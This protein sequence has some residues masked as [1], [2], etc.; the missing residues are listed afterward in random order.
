MQDGKENGLINVTV[1]D[2]PEF[3]TVNMVADYLNVCRAT[4]YNWCKSGDIPCLKIRNTLRIRKAYL[5]QW[6]EAK[7]REIGN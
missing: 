6:I 1:D 7:E 5:L 3:M 2:L 4:A